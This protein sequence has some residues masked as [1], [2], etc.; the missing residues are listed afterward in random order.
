M[1]LVFISSFHLFC[2]PIR[3]LTINL[4]CYS[5]SILVPAPFKYARA[6]LMLYRLFK[7]GSR[8]GGFNLR[9]L[10]IR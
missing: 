4:K 1:V 5:P 10:D 8:Q 2:V 9:G 6:F 7:I 3:K